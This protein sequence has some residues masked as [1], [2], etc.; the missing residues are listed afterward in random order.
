VPE[1]SLTPGRTAVV[2]DVAQCMREKFAAGDT[3]GAYEEYMG[4]TDGEEKIVLWAMLKQDS[5]LRSA[6]KAHGESLKGK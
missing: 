3:I 6:I 4:I 5:K 2:D 1:I